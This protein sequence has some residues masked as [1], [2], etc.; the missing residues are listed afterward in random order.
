MLAVGATM[1]EGGTGLA[2]VALTLCL[3]EIEEMWRRTRPSLRVSLISESQQLSVARNETA[4]S[5]E[6]ATRST[7]R[8]IQAAAERDTFQTRMCR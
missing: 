1:E 7:G 2:Q 8:P 5:R 3:A 6:P 4:R